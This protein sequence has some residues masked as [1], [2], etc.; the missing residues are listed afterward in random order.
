MNGEPGFYLMTRSALACDGQRASP[1][2]FRAGRR[3][4]S[5]LLAIGLI[6]LSLAVV[7]W[8]TGYKLSLYRPHP[9]PS[10]RVGLWVGPERGAR[11]RSAH[12][13][14]TAPLTPVFQLLVVSK[15]ASPDHAEATLDPSVAAALHLR[16]R[17]LLSTL[18][19]PPARSL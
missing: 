11:V 14:T 15:P 19:S 17:L 18:R 3:V 4:T 12:T 2:G 9:S 1:T 5:R 7:L 10:L 16:F 13:K 6:G 8:G